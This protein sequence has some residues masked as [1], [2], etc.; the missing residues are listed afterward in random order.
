[1]PFPLMVMVCGE[2]R[3]LLGTG[4]WAATSAL[5][6]GLKLIVTARSSFG[7]SVP[8]ND[9]HLKARVE[10]GNDRATVLCDEFLIDS[11]IRI[12]GPRSGTSYSGRSMQPTRPFSSLRRRLKRRRSHG[13]LKRGNRSL[14]PRFTE[15]SAAS[16]RQ[17]KITCHRS[18]RNSLPRRPPSD[19]C[20][21]PCS[22]ERS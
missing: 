7:P 17:R 1:V 2:P 5:L 10:A 20:H 22:N 12:N 19:A 8:L 21:H 13:S 14:A 11:W 4:N 18:R 6:G 3:A 9:A 15:Q 16:Q